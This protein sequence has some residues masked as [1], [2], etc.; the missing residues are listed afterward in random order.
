MWIGIPMGAVNGEAGTAPIACELWITL[1]IPGPR[2]LPPFRPAFQKAHS[3]AGRGRCIMYVFM[4]SF[5]LSQL[6]SRASLIGGG[7]VL[8]FWAL[9]NLLGSFLAAI[10]GPCRFS[11]GGW[12]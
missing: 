7:V 10:W 12:V 6:L 2:F 3:K 8:H 9:I 11:L 1:S 5:P 4:H